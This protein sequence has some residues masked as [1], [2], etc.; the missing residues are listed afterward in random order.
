MA[1]FATALTQVASNSYAINCSNP[2]VPK[3]ASTARLADAIF[4]ALCASESMFGRWSVSQGETLIGEFENGV[5]VYPL[6]RNQTKWLK[7]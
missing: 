6:T 4:F 1:S 7:I 5:R 2:L 3:I